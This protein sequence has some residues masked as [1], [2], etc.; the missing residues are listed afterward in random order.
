M[1]KTFLAAIAIVAAL[2]I[3]L[4]AS[5]A[6]VQ[7]QAGSGSLAVMGTDPPTGPQGM[8]DATAHYRSVQA[9][10]AG[11][12]MS[13]GWTQLSG[14]GTLDLTA[15]GQ[16]QVMAVSQVNAADYDAFRF[17]VESVSVVYQGQTYT[18]AVASSTITAT[19]QKVQVSPGG[20]ASAL[21]DMRTF[22]QNAGTPSAPQL[23]FTASAYATGVPPQAS[24]SLSL[25]V[26]ATVSLSGQPWFA[27][28]ESQTSANVKVVSASLA[29]GSLTVNLQNSGGVSGQIQEI[30]VTP[31]SA[32]GSLSTY[33]PASYGG[34]AVFTVAGSGSVQQATTLQ[35][36]TLSSAGATI[37]SGASSTLTYSGDIA[38]GSGIVSGEQYIVTCVGA[39]TYASTTVVAS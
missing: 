5:F 21:V 31:V 19:S 28:F 17:E 20:S 30:I 15:S 9:H 7:S 6:L 38:Q 24:T 11:S 25:Q 36:S 37:A 33:L 26:G 3:V 4:A 18:A 16:A 12:D 39:N 13:S 23:I 22:I 27:S 14:S 34:S 35:A 2:V 10:R 29:S 8:S 1:K 32:F